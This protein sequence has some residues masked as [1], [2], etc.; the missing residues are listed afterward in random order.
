MRRVR[1]ALLDVRWKVAERSSGS[2]SKD[3]LILHPLQPQ[4]GFHLCPGGGAL[5]AVFA[6][7]P[8][9]LLGESTECV[10]LGDRF[11]VFVALPPKPEEVRFRDDNEGLTPNLEMSN[12]HGYCII[13]C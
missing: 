3:H 2:V 11:P 10:V 5:A 7:G 6:E 9:F 1:D 4:F 8:E 13:H 12:G